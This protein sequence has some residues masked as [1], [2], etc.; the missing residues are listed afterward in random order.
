MSLGFRFI[1][2]GLIGWCA[3]ILWTGLYDA[4][5]GTSQGRPLDKSE[6]WR[7]AGRTYLW[8]FPL[9]G[10]AALAFE[11]VHDLVRGL[12][13][14]LRGAIYMAGIFCVEATAGWSLKRLTGRCPW[15]YSYARWSALGGTIR[16]DYAPVWFLFGFVL[17]R[18][19][20]TLLCSAVR[21]C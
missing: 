12:G 7:L 13:W 2:Y 16:I 3:E 15:D 6:R 20:D 18:V 5:I 1:V 10:S 21:A 11:P 4:I 8:M 14:P 9:Y 19:H 17:E